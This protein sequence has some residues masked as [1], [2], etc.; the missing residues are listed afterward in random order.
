MNIQEQIL[1]HIDRK[2]REELNTHTAL[3][4][5]EGYDVVT[6][7]EQL[8]KSDNSLTQKSVQE[9]IDDLIQ[10]GKVVKTARTYI[11][12]QYLSF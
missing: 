11:L 3:P 5:P 6:L 7:F 1:T 4:Q 2:C 8:R 12:P 9:A 10:A